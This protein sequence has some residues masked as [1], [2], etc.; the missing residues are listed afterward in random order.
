VIETWRDLVLAPGGARGEVSPPTLAKVLNVGLALVLLIVLVCVCLLSLHFNWQ[1]IWD[2]RVDLFKGWVIT[3]EI[4]AAALVLSTVGGF[5][6]A[7][8]QRSFV[9]PL[10]YFAK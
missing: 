10:R 3:L 7:L 4:T 8:G 2:Y 5:V 1:V 6:L 9:L